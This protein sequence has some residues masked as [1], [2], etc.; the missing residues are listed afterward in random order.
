MRASLFII[1][2]FLFLNTWLLAQPNVNQYQFRRIDI[3]KGLSHNQ[4]NC[5][6]KDSKG[7]MW[8]GTMSGLNR[9][10]GYQFKVFKHDIKDSLS[11]DDD[12]VTRV[13]ELPDGKLLVATRSWMNIYD[14]KTEKFSHNIAGYFASLG[15]PNGVVMKTVKTPNGDFYFLIEKEGVF[16]YSISTR[17]ASKMR[18]NEKS[19]ITSISRNKDG[20]FWVIC[21][22][23]SIELLDA[24]TEKVVYHTDVVNKYNNTE[25]MNYQIFADNE[26]ELWVYTFGDTK[27]V[28]RFNPA[29]NQLTIINKESVPAKLNTNLVMGILQ[30]NQSNIWIYTDHGG[31]NVFDKKKKTIQY[32][33]ND[34]DNNNSLSQNS[35]NTA[36]KDDNGIIWVGTYKKGIN[37]YHESI[38]KFPLYKNHPSQPNSLPY[39]DVNR[40]VEDAKGN[41]WIGT[42]GGGLIY[43]DKGRDVFTQYKHQS[44]N[45]NSLCNDVI[46]G[47]CMDKK[48]RLWIG[49][50]FGGM[51][52]FDGK[53]FMHYQHNPNDN[54][55]IADNRI[56]SIYED[57]ANNLWVGTLGAGLDRFDR[58]KHIFYHHNVNIPNSI[59]SNYVSVLTE[60]KKGDLVI[61]TASGMDILEK[62]TD[63]F[64]HY[65]YNPQ[66]AGSL[67]NGNVNSLLIDSKGRIWVGTREGL[68]ILNDKTKA[69]QHF[70]I[71]NGLP[72][73][74]VLNILE[75]NKHSFWISTPKGI[76][77]IAVAENS[78]KD[79]AIDISC[80]NYDE[81][82][83]LQGTQF[84]EN[85]ALKT[86]K[87]ELIFGGA[88]G[89]N[90]F[91]PES[92]VPNKQIPNIVFTDFQVFNKSISPG[93][94]LNGKVLLEGSITETKSITLN[95]N[96]NV[97]AIEFAA[98]NYSNADKNKYAYKL[99]G[100]KDEWLVADGKNRKAVFTNLDPGNYTF[101]VKTANDNGKWN[102]NAI[103]LSIKILPPFWRAP[104]AYSIYLLIVVVVLYIGR[105]RI[106]HKA[107]EKFAIEQERVE[108]QRMHELD[109]MKIKFFTNVSHEFRTPLSLI[110]A[111]VDK[112]LK[113]A[114]EEGQKQ[115]LQLIHRNARRLLNLVNQLLDF[116]KMEERELKLHSTKGDIVQYIN[117]VSHSFS[118]VAD[119]KNI[120]F[121]FHSNIDN[122]ETSFDTDKIERILFNLLSN[123]FKFTPENGHVGVDVFVKAKEDSN[124]WFEVEI[125]VQDTGIG[126][127]ANKQEKIFERFFQNDIPGSMVNQGSGIGL[128]ITKE[129][130]KLHGGNI[131][132]ESEPNKG[133]CFKV[134]IPVLVVAIEKI[135]SAKSNDAPVIEMNGVESLEEIDIA[136]EIEAEDLVVEEKPSM[137]K[138]KKPTVL[139]VEDNDD[140]RFYLKDNLK[141]YFNIL[142]AIN[143]KLGWQKA[144]A[145]HP[146]LIVS[147]ISMPEMDGID[148]CKKI[149]H[150]S[151]TKHVPVILLTALIGEEQQLKG[152]ETGANDYMTKPFNFEILL[153]KIKNQL[154]QQEQIKKTYQ[155][156]VEAKPTDI[157]VESP[158]E[159]FMQQVLTL[160]E[161]NISEPDF[162]VEDMSRGMFMSRVALYKKILSL[163]GKT[164][165]EF[166]RQIRLKRAAQLLEKSDMTVAE[167][168]YEVGFNSPKYFSKYFKTE[169]DKLPSVYMEEMRRK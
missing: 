86:K 102:D 146:D 166:I 64:T 143:G 5:I 90:V 164:P 118:D 80:R 1:L 39:D 72:D 121:S 148:L 145:A 77:N 50:Y 132:V 10:D 52:C 92:I 18:I 24:K 53:T 42:N 69:F 60:N 157:V 150:D 152:L 9:F 40:F 38:I 67:S 48:Q 27:G 20:N 33:V 32:I 83:G 106:I 65:F 30:D 122:L 68:N 35:I 47:L 119:K 149:K 54:S 88:N 159:K 128:A 16:K 4:I 49:T 66:D 131:T 163:T 51:D 71:E 31:I 111:P 123:A 162:S 59:Q 153:S 81:S 21:N 82:D 113:R 15:L 87:G 78:G 101:Y 114:M 23:G 13:L 126:I 138:N 55:S 34:P 89:F 135:V 12:F 168:A 14:P 19:Y 160:I 95:Y 79:G 11:I 110:L 127:E 28:C 63:N 104:L 103:K 73:N 115:Q 136:D 8:F 25:L 7:F 2:S 139:L 144:L 167:V 46:V 43:F 76:S 161:K 142:E 120:S 109:L 37:C 124:N 45:N 29:T 156:Q 151:R 125:A 116:R 74:A 169:Y 94:E 165:I 56:W 133:S 6:L 117:E 84:N 3:S 57:A 137:P 140:F 70:T 100:F 36:Y 91:Q 58:D 61:G 141:E 97:I 75:D 154:T 112:M 98:L 44:G 134:T 85:A 99:E 26:N 107:R 22:D 105:I 108:A 41:I 155:K 129:F 147:D 96:Q 62:G 17:K 158:Q 93:E 130:V